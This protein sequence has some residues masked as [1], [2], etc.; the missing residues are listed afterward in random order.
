MGAVLQARRVILLA[1]GANKAAAV[2]AMV[3]G[4]L[5][6]RCPASLLQLHGDV[7]VWVDLAAGRGLETS[8]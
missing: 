3:R 4:P 8:I 7:E 1:F 5:T 2:T 6:T